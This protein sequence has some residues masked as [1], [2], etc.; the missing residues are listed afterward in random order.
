VLPRTASWV[1]LSA[2][3]ASRSARIAVNV[4]LISSAALARCA[5]NSRVPWMSDFVRTNLYASMDY[6]LC[7]VFGNFTHEAMC[8]MNFI[9]CLERAGYIKINAWPCLELQ[10][11]VQIIG[12]VQITS[13]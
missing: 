7:L 10:T 6:K 5:A 3:F 11:F 9:L 13:E 4:S 8:A 2:S 1:H 12:V